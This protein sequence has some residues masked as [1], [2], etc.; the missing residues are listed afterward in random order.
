[1]ALGTFEKYADALELFWIQYVVAYDLQ[2]QRSLAASFRAQFNSYERT[3]RERWNELQ[4]S[5]AALN[6][7]AVNGVKIND[8][9]FVTLVLLFSSVPSSAQTHRATVRG[10][11]SN[12]AGNDVAGAGVRQAS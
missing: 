8:T 4:N 1:M 5:L 9:I 6:R 12:V 7:I 10:R 2:E 3:A 11:V